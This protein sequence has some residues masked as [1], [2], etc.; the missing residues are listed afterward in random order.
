MDRDFE[1]IELSVVER[2]FG[3]FDVCSSAKNSTE[4]GLTAPETHF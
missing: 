2:C 1:M 4:G 3:F